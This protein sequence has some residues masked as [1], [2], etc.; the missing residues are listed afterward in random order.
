MK[1]PINISFALVILFLT[2]LAHGQ[3]NDL[4][5][6]LS[7][8]WQLTSLF[9]QGQ[10]RPPLN[11]NLVLQFEFHKDGTNRLFW[12]RKNETGFCERKAYYAWNQES[13]LQKVFWTNPENALS[14][15]ADPD[16]Q[17]GRTSVT[18]A[19]IENSRLHLYLALGDEPLIYIWKRIE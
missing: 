12:S 2:T 8:H 9:Y 3:K 16:M 13:L 15:G 7:G 5:E 17:L 14:C 19:K 10:E 1:T 4:T 18:Q 11:P 6:T